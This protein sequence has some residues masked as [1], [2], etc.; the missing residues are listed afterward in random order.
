ME[1]GADIPDDYHPGRRIMLSARI[2]RSAHN[3]DFVL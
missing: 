3:T 1:A 2:A